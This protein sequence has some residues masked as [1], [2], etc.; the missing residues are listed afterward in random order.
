MGCTSS[1]DNVKTAEISPAKV[2]DGTSV[3]VSRETTNI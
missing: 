2:A 1:A 3:D